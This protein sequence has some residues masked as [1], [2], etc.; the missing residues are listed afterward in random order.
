MNNNRVLFILHLPPPIHGAAMIGKYI[1]DSQII[2]KEL[3]CRF[4]NLAT[5]KD[6][7]DIGKIRIKKL[8]QFYKLLRH[9][10]KEVK[11]FKPQLVYVTPNSKG[12]AF[13]KD[14][15][16][17]QMLKLMG[18]KIIAHYHNKGV[19]QRQNNIIDNL[20]YHIF[21]KNLKVILLAQT[22]YEDIQKYVLPEN[23]FICP[24][25][26]PESQDSGPVN[27][28]NAETKLLFLSNL[29]IEKG[30]FTLLDACKIL[31][32]KGYSFI[33]DFVGGET[34]EINATQFVTETQK[35][36][37]NNI[38]FYR[39]KKYG[40]D[41]DRMLKNAN[42]FILPT[43]NECFPL[44][45]LEAMQQKLPCISTYEGGITDIIIQNETG[46]IVQK[47]SAQ[48]LAEKIEILLK[49]PIKQIEMGNKGFERYQKFFTL[50]SFEMRLTSILKT[51]INDTADKI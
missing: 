42:I 22:L 30:V 7:S 29:L 3:N 51:A 27:R 36:G 28:N 25:G 44:V 31:K 40:I 4:I 21:F 34:A 14:F 8:V 9:I 39:G 48:E 2:N 12:S 37:I 46:Y 1:H 19:S 24:N 13:Y 38:V 11:L 35:R 26:I 18:C 20:L 23:I 10:Q 5:A 33:C 17:I 50:K 49:N 41:K 6:L 15:I 47:K 45:L 32:D 16:V 43:Y